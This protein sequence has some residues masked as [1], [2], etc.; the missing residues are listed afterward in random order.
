MEIF[1]HPKIITGCTCFP[2]PNLDDK[3]SAQMLGEAAQGLTGSLLQR[4]LPGGVA[5]CLS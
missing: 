4:E 1:L 5:V 3:F 2:V